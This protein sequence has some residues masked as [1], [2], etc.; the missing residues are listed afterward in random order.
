[1][2]IG[3]F[4]ANLMSAFSN[5]NIAQMFQVVW[6]FADMSFGFGGLIIGIGTLFRK[7][8]TRGSGIVL[9]L[10]AAFSNLLWFSEYFDKALPR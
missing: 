10:L 3:W 8:W 5:G 2:H 6:M 1:M 9:C 4:M 7:H